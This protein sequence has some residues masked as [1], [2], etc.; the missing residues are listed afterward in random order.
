M[1]VGL[2][3]IDSHAKV[4]K[5][6]ATVYPNL[7]LCKIAAYHRSQG[8]TVEWAMPLFEEYDIIYR[9]KVFNFTPDDDR[10]YNA[11][12]VIRGGT[13][14]S[15]ASQLPPPHRR[16]TTRLLHLPHRAARRVIRLPHKGLP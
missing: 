1:R 7:A 15:I 13:G 12:Q 5:W 16:D 2:I 11:K 6:G 8:D 14:Y 9:S 10:T 3:D 4:K